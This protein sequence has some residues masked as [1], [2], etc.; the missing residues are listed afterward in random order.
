MKYSELHRLLRKAGCYP[1]GEGRHQ[2]WYSPI[3]G[4]VFP[5]SHHESE[6]VKYG[7]LQKILKVS[8]LKKEK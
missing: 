6:E 7:T 3:T 5:T 1:V 4:I 8:G 2:K